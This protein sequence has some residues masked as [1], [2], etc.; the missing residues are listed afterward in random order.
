MS[1]ANKI[2]L[3]TLP[4]ISEQDYQDAIRQIDAVRG[5][6][7]DR[8][9][10]IK[11]RGIDPSIALPQGNW[12]GPELNNIHGLYRQ[13]LSA[14]FKKINEL[15]F[16]CYNFSGYY[17][18]NIFKPGSKVIRG[19]D[20]DMYLQKKNQ[21]PSQL[22]VAPPKLMGE[23]GWDVEGVPFNQDTL[24][25]QGRLFLFYKSGI[26]DWALKRIQETGTL[27]VIEIGAGYGGWA[28]HLKRLFTG[29]QYYLV[30]LPE[31]L[32]FSSVYLKIADSDATHYL[33]S[34]EGDSKN[35]G[36]G[37]HYIPNYMLDDLMQKN[38]R[39]DLAINTWS[40]GE[41]IPEQVNYY[42]KHLSTMLENEGILFEQ[43]VN[44][45]ELSGPIYSFPKE[46]L[47]KHFN[48]REK[49]SD[50][51]CITD[52]WFNDDCPVQIWANFDF[53]AQILRPYGRPNMKTKDKFP[54]N[55]WAA[56][57]RRALPLTAIP[58]KG[59]VRLLNRI[60]GRPDSSKS[61]DDIK[62]YG[63]AILDFMGIRRG[64]FIRKKLS[65]A[66]EFLRRCLPGSNK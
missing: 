51:K 48:F 55:I 25:N 11:A 6:V 42:G 28:Y 9:A 33:Y 44:P 23:I 62:Y 56:A 61:L 31:C 60:S 52:K 14:D 46:E 8:D 47:K 17:L 2:T 16:H 64:S 21:L 37:Y 15:R 34:G 66:I 29:T 27:R 3:D 4:P 32:L 36:I 63:K 39:F 10:Y 20:L 1:L 49:I 38:L 7:E 40:F 43:N 26:Y 53:E 41:M 35:E 5:L 59:C 19:V 24:I 58:V 22:R 45:K 13:F 12:K 50:N 54:Y 65:G 57:I 18:E 30:D